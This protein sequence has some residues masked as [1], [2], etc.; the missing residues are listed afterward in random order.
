MAEEISVPSGVQESAELAPESPKLDAPVKTCSCRRRSLLPVLVSLL[1][2]SAALT[3]PLWV[4]KLYPQIA[5]PSA[6]PAALPEDAL[7]AIDA[8]LTFLENE[9]PAASAPDS[10]LADQLSSLQ[11]E[12]AKLSARPVTDLASLETRLAELEAKSA[13]SIS[14]AQLTELSDRVDRLGTAQLEARKDD[15][16]EKVF[17]SASVQL[18]SAW[19]SGQPFDAPWQALLAASEQSAPDLVTT[20]N[21]IAPV[22][23]PWSGSGLPLLSRLQSEYDAASRAALLASQP[24]GQSWWQQSL[25]RL[26]GLVVI[27]RTG[28]AIPADEVSVEATLARAQTKLGSGDL[29]G[30]VDL[31]ATLDGDAAAAL[32]KWMAGAR[33]RLRADGLAATLST[34]LAAQMTPASE[35]PP[36]PE[37]QPASEAQP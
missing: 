20:L 7:Q 4:G 36:V 10:A 26:Q 27:R 16:A 37:V 32:D 21:D 8:R 34:R 33:A 1:A 31:I 15:T 6:A 35:T 14:R 17:A 19:Q 3:Q 12:V 5:P 25:Q 24:K 22:L 18:V 23:L 2:L 9:K 13:I 11:Q 28:T 30:A 29:A